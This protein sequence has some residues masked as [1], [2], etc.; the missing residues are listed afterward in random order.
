MHNFPIGLMAEVRQ[1]LQH[2]WEQKKEVKIE[3]AEVFSLLNWDLQEK[4]TIYM[5]GVIL[6][7]VGA[8]NMITQ[9][10]EP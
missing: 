1:F 10:S 8:L 6:H 7:N 5:N 4:I 2:Q 3:Q 9:S